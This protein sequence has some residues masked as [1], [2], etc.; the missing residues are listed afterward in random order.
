MN[1]VAEMQSTLDEHK[2]ALPNGAYV[3]LCNGLKTLHSVT[4]LYTIIYAEFLPD[5]R[6]VIYQKRVRIIEQGDMELPDN[7]GC[8]MQWSS[9]FSA[10]RLPRELPAAY[11]PFHTDTHSYVIVLAIEPYLKRAREEDA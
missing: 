8:A 2:E 11:A 5:D 1:T 6:G 4:N 10:W 7:C 9:I 3:Q